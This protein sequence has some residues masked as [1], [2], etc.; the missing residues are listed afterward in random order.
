MAPVEDNKLTGLVAATFTPFTPEGWVFVIYPLS[1]SSTTFLVNAD[2]SCVCVHLVA[3]FC[4]CISCPAHILPKWVYWIP[5]KCS[6]NSE[7]NLTEIGPYIDYLIEKQ[8]V[9]N[10]FGKF[11]GVSSS[12]FLHWTFTCLS[13]T[14]TLHANMQI[15]NSLARI[16][17]TV[18]ISFKWWLFQICIYHS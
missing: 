7:V 10:I 6:Q 13:F 16:L 17:T 3:M 8:G 4:I 2:L 11:W 9:K 12:G 1:T 15:F 5:F 18:N 14:I